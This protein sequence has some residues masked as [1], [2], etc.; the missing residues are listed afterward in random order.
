[1]KPG[2]NQRSKQ[3]SQDLCWKVDDRAQFFVLRS[4][5]M[6]E[7]RNQHVSISIRTG[8]FSYAPQIFFPPLSLLLKIQSFYSLFI[9]TAQLTRRQKHFF[10][11][12]VLSDFGVGM[13]AQPLQ[14]AAGIVILYGNLSV[15][16]SVQPLYAAVVYYF[17]SVSFKTMKGISIEP[18]LALGLGITHRLV[19]TVRKVV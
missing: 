7:L 14:V 3:R 6:H 16:C 9:N 11:S 1:M 4:Y 8:T 10:Y 17:C 12:L 2:K 15:F 5:S 18:F 19:V 13:A